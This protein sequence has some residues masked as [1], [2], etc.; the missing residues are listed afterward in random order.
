MQ[1]VAQAASREQKQFGARFW[2]TPPPRGG[3]VVRSSIVSAI[4]ALRAVST[5]AQGPVTAVVIRR[6]G[7]ADAGARAIAR[8]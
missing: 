4:C 6:M 7:G 1:A 2:S 8:E 5:K 3:V